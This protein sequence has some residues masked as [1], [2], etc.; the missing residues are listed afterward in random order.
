M[1]K[2]AAAPTRESGA[3]APWAPAAWALRAL[4]SGALALACL[5]PGTVLAEVAGKPRI[6]DGATLEIAGQRFRLAGIETPAPDQTCRRAGQEYACGTVARAM[7]WDLVGGREVR[8]EPVVNA[9]T[10]D[11]G[12]AGGGI[13]LATCRAGDTDLNAG[14][15]VAGWALA[16]PAAA[17]SYGALE[18]EARSARR[19]LWTGEFELPG[20]RSQKAE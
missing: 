13:T 8:C 7:L 9:G 3:P 17:A 20:G 12:S 5:A 18:D 15:V 10:A 4:T 14:M 19:G 16:D 1:V 11:T 6:I 2:Q